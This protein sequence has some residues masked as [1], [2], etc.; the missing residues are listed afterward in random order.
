MQGVPDKSTLS[1]Y[2]GPFV[3]AYP[4]T[5]GATD[6]PAALATQQMVDTA[7]MTRTACRAW[8]R[9]VLATSTPALALVSPN[10]YDSVWGANPLNLA[11]TFAHVSGGAFSVTWAGTT[12]GLVYDELNVQ[13]ALNFQRATVNIEGSPPYFG[14]VYSVSPNSVTFTVWTVSG[15]VF[16]ANDAV[17]SVAHLMVF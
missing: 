5:N 13:H 6:Q 8:I 15:G 17:G 3:D 9:L 2:G 4:V 11:P 16:V 1:T 10:S 7:G 14:A 12:G